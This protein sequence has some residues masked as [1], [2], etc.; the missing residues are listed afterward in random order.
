[1]QYMDIVDVMDIEFLF[2][3]WCSVC[4]IIADLWTSNSAL[5]Q[6]IIL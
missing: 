3:N 6:L 2:Q 5:D 1:M 4:N